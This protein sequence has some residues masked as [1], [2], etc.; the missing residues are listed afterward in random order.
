MLSQSYDGKIQ[1]IQ[2]SAAS[3][4]MQPT[5]DREKQQLNLYTPAAPLPSSETASRIGAIEELYYEVSLQVC[6]PSGNQSIVGVNRLHQ[7][8]IMC[9]NSI[10][11]INPYAKYI[12]IVAEL[13][14]SFL[15]NPQPESTFA[16]NQSCRSSLPL[17]LLF[18]PNFKFLC[19]V[20]SFGRSKSS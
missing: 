12:S 1:N 17:Q 10:I 19:E 3:P 13:N 20:L 16:Q 4:D 7:L 9:R 2:S 6:G 8:L 5:N 15:P 18:W 14:H 11:S